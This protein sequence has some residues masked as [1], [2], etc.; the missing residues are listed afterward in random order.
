[1]SVPANLTPYKNRWVALVRARPVGVGANAAEAYRAA[2]RTCPKDIPRMVFVDENGLAHR[3][4]A[5]FNL[6]FQHNLLK[7][8]LAVWPAGWGAVYLVGGAVRDGLLGALAPEADL[9]LLVP[10][11]ALKIARQLADTL[12]AACFPLDAGRDVGRVIFPDRR[13]LDIASFR[14]DTLS[15]DLSARDFTINAMALRLDA[16]NPQL[17]DPTHGYDDLDTRLIRVASE[18]AINNDPLRILRGVRLA[19][20]LDFTIDPQTQR[21]MRAAAPGLAR[22]SP[23]RVR[24]ELLKLLQGS[25]PGGAINQL[26][27]PGALACILPEAVAMEGVAQSAPHYR[28]VFEHTMTVLN[29]WAAIFPFDTPDLA[30]LAPVLEL[31]R[32]YFAEELA[33]NLKRSALMPMIALLHDIGKPATAR[34]GSDGRIRFWRHPQEGAATA[35]QIMERLHFSVQAIRFVKT[36]VLHHMRPLLLV[37]QPVVSKRAIHRFLRDTGNA[38]PAIAVFSLIDHLGIYPPGEG[39]AVWTRLLQVVL[40]ICRAYF[41]PGPVP[42]LTGTEVMAH[43]DL[44]PGPQ[45]G[46]LL[47]RLNE[48]QAIGQVSTPAEAIAFLQTVQ[49]GPPE[50]ES[51]KEGYDET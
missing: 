36:A 41:N 9:D 31:L 37:N 19:A 35:Q 40:R 49:A 30:P 11:H 38:A 5:R 44:S 12:G 45:I 29:G 14:G 2:K 26:R 39:D 6:W 20:A 34:Q 43:L 10:R 50:K 47:A 3:Q 7:Q 42:L 46:R 13:Y 8:V 18:T 23:E 48:A 4:P 33:G 22:V 21:R 32:V 27:R 51:G 1:M 25:R 24:D 17:I 28:P 15:A 16:D